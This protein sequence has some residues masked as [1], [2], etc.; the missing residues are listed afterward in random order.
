MST[1][2]SYHLTSDSLEICVDEAG[3]GSLA[4]PVFVGAVVLKPGIPVPPELKDSKKMTKP[5]KAKMRQ[6]IEQNALYWSVKSVDNTRIDEIDILN[7]TFEGMQAAIADVMEQMK[8]RKPD[9]ILIDGNRFVANSPY[10]VELVVKGDS[11]YAGIAAASVLAKE[12]HDEYIM[13]A[14]E[15]NPM[16]DVLYDLSHNNAYGSPRHLQGIREYGPSP[17]HRMSFGCCK[18]GIT[19][20]EKACTWSISSLMADSQNQLS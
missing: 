14:I 20:R 19:K 11:I 18:D 9:C 8:P 7:A 4:F 16:L 15:E 10:P 6:W 12:Y 2:K 3:R 13:Q 1:L 17:F 5:R